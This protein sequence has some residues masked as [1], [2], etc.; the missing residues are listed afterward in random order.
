MFVIHVF[1]DIGMRSRL[2][3][4][5]AARGDKRSPGRE[6]RGFGSSRGF[7]YFERLV[8]N[9]DGDSEDMAGKN[10][11]AVF[12][13][14]KATNVAVSG[15]D[16]LDHIEA[17]RKL[18]RQGE[19][20]RGV[21]VITTGGNDL[22]HNYGRSAP[23]ECAMYGA[24]LEQAGP[25]IS[26]FRGRLDEMTCKE[27]ALY[28]MHDPS[29]YIT[30]DCILD[31]TDLSFEQ[32]GKDRMRV[33]GP[34]AR[35]RTPTYKVVV[36]YHDGWIG[37]GEVGFQ[38]ATGVRDAAVADVYERGAGVSRAEGL[39]DASLAGAGAAAARGIGMAGAQAPA[40][41]F[42][43][44]MVGRVG[45]GHAVQHLKPVEVPV[46]AV[47]Q[48]AERNGVLLAPR[49]VRHNSTRMLV[50]SFRSSCCSWSGSVSIM[51]WQ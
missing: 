13:K 44:Q 21:V 2:T 31:I 27:Q 8:Q 30:P 49:P 16:S 42:V 28:E 14:L 20:V 38:R 32:V 39:Q 4:I 46:E 25:W 9:P 45:E 3:V 37:E 51:F 19:D 50:S 41:L 34:R 5:D 15:S 12:P 24:T 22:I 26:N 7:S 36:G 1:A 33:I 35:P 48:D 18:E 47:R 43:A 17:I 6:S 10:L 23:E 29:S 40:A 11:S